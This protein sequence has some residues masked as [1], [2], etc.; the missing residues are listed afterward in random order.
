[1]KL[2]K[3]LEILTNEFEI[4]LLRNIFNCVLLYKIYLS[5]VYVQQ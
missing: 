4:G 1:M 2:K 3:N 5:Y